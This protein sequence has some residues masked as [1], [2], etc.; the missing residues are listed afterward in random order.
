M[1]G[2]WT[3]ILQA[4]HFLRDTDFCCGKQKVPEASGNPGPGAAPRLPQHSCAGRALPSPVL[5]SGPSPVPLAVRAQPPAGRLR[6]EPRSHLP[7]GGQAYRA[8]DPA[9]PPGGGVPHRA[10]SPASWRR[11]TALRRSRSPR[12]RWSRTRCVPHRSPTPGGRDEHARR[13]P[14]L[15]P[16][17][18][19]K[20]NLLQPPQSTL[21]HPVFTTVGFKAWPERGHP[22]SALT[23]QVHGLP[24]QPPTGLPTPS[25]ELV[26]ID[27]SP[28]TATHTP[29]HG[30]PDLPL[31]LAARGPGSRRRGCQVLEARLGDGFPA[32]EETAEACWAR[33]ASISFP[34][35]GISACTLTSTPAQGREGRG[36]PPGHPP[37]HPPPAL[38]GSLRRLDSP[39]C[40]AGFRARPRAA[41]KLGTLG[42][43]PRRSHHCP[44]GRSYTY[45]SRVLQVWGPA[46]LR[47]RATWR[48]RDSG[49]TRAGIPRPAAVPEALRPPGLGCWPMGRGWLRRR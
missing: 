4:A 26:P 29:V 17:P 35:P 20:T 30:A 46:D 8:R 47:R 45:A 32:E 18:S 39:R 23:P 21:L 3:T 27:P 28:L 7:L 22:R 42:P 48:R 37:R 34:S 25:R 6:Q 38:R 24:L 2:V 12:T 1:Q 33:S 11:S 10:H 16:S 13:T 49:R 15:P 5:A 31:R 40:P 36:G 9:P 44:A 41:A 43:A 14:A 19:P